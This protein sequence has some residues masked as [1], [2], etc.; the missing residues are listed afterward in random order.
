VQHPTSSSFERSGNEDETIISF[1]TNFV[2][3]NQDFKSRAYYFQI[4]PAYRT[5]RNLEERIKPKKALFSAF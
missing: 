5:D 3:L 1:P 4:A 2:A